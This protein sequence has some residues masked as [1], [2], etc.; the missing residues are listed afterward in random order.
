M[1]D[2]LIKDPNPDLIDIYNLL[3]EIYR[4]EKI[5]KV[6]ITYNI[7][8]GSPDIQI[9]DPVT[10]HLQLSKDYEKSY[11]LL[12]LVLDVYDEGVFYGMSEEQKNAML[13]EF[14]RIFVLYAMDKFNYQLNEE[15]NSEKM[16]LKQLLSA[17]IISSKSSITNKG[18]DLLKSIVNE[19]EFYID[20]YDIYGDTLIKDK[21]VT[22]NTG[23]GDNLIVPVLINDGIDPY[24]ALFVSALYMGNMDVF[25]FD[26]DRILTESP[27]KELFRLT[28]AS[29][30][31]DID[32]DVLGYIISEGKKAVDAMINKE[33][34]ARES[35]NIRHRINY[36]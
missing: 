12:D 23:Y 2:A 30:I 4:Q 8:N 19:A 10:L 9:T 26:L 22:F 1:R 5:G 3:L 35:E 11:N 14:R 20:N 24:R 36:F 15:S 29:P 27:F 16:I 17:G 7:N 34:R 25:A 18:Y 13:D 21:K 28:A 6:S 31:D 33:E 32:G